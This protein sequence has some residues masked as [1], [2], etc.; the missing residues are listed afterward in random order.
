MYEALTRRTCSVARNDTDP[1][2]PSAHWL[3]IMHEKGGVSDLLTPSAVLTMS[4]LD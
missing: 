2:D 4:R 1:T 3:G